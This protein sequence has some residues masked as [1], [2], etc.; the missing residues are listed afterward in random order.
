MPGHP[1]EQ[2]CTV[3]DF[4]AFE[5]EPDVHYELVNGRIVAMAPPLASHGALLINIGSLLKTRLHPPC[6]PYAQAGLLVPERSDTFYEA[7]IAVSCRPHDR[8][9]RWITA[10]VLVVEIL[11]PSTRTHDQGNKVPDY[12]TI[13][14]MQDILLVD[15]ERRRIQHWRR[16]GDAWIVRDVIGDGAITP[17]AFGGGRITLEEIYEG[18][19]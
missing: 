5:G 8:I 12:G 3:D 6:R 17:A 10:P 9:E 13:P 18:V 2:L 4:L 16:D 15:S 1:A 11:S 19:L 7:D 14:S